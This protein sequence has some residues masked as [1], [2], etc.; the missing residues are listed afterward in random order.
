MPS[1]LLTQPILLS[2]ARARFSELVEQVTAEPGAAVLIGHRNRSRSVVLVDAAHYEVLLERAH[3]A[4]HPSGKAFRLAGSI[5]VEP[6]QDPVAFIEAER[7]RQGALA[8]EK[9]AAF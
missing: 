6:E 4:D 2:E 7:R 8:V 3:A 1:K 5:P 9:R